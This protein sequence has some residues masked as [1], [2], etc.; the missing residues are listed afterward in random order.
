[1]PQPVTMMVDG[2][3]PAGFVYSG[4]SG[5]APSCGCLGATHSQRTQ[6]RTFRATSPLLRSGHSITSI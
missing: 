2:C 5:S 1:M 3:L 4:L 6:T